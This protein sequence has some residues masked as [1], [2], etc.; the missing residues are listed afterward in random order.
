MTMRF[1]RCALT[2]L[3]VK[4]FNWHIADS[5]LL[6]SV[7]L[8]ISLTSA[9]ASPLGT[10]CMAVCPSSLLVPLDVRGVPRTRASS[11][12]NLQETIDVRTHEEEVL[13]ARGVQ[14]DDRYPG[15]P[16]W[17]GRDG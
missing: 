3:L 4:P 11:C 6:S 13:Q 10:S 12:R 15:R 17:G 9:F 5:C 7:V 8:L 1:W 2:P 16:G 14:D